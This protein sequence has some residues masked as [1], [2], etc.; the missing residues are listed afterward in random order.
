MT[1]ELC[2]LRIG[3]ELYCEAGRLSIQDFLGSGGQGEV[4]RISLNGRD[5]ALKYYFRDSC[6]QSVKDNLKRI[7]DEPVRSSS[8]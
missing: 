3:D 2:A 4:Y 7:I 6:T 8:F 5:Y 1:N